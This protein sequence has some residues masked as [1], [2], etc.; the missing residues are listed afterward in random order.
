MDKYDRLNAITA[1]LLLCAFGWF[2]IATSGDATVVCAGLAAL[3]VAH[4][5]IGYVSGR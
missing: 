2:A 1:G 3:A 4:F 5:V